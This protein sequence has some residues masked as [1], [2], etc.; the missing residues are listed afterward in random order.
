ML[1]FAHQSTLSEDA[2][3]GLIYFPLLWSKLD[4]SQTG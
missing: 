3:F 4:P 1:A 2:L